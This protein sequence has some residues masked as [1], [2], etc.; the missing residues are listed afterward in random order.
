LGHGERAGRIARQQNPL[1]ELGGGLKMVRA[2]V[3]LERHGARRVV[4]PRGLTSSR[5]AKPADNLR[6]AVE[7]TVEATIGSAER[8]RSAA[9]GALDDLV[10]SVED[11]RKGAEERLARGR[12]SMADAI[13]G[14]RPAT[15]DDVKELRA[16]LRAIGRRLDRI[17]ERLPKRR[18]TGGASK[19]ASGASKRTSKS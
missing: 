4:G 16:E 9:Q 13:E 10:D 17:E 6:D 14:R 12:K 7:R 3:V 19:R 11:L 5:M 1:G 2:H 18:S 8:S 15:S